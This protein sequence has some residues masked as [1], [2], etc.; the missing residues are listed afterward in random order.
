MKERYKEI[1][2]NLNDLKDI[3]KILSG[4][5]GNASMDLEQLIARVESFAEEQAL[6]P[7][8][9]EVGMAALEN[10]KEFIK[11]KLGIVYKPT[12]IDWSTTSGQFPGAKLVR[13]DIL[14]RKIKCLVP[15][16]RI[17]DTL[18]EEKLVNWISIT[19][20]GRYAYYVVYLP[21][22]KEAVKAKEDAC[23]S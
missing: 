3:L 19:T 5:I 15:Y 20:K 7:G 4:D 17:I 16:R 11:Q 13:V 22:C 2:K 14:Y 6:A 9:E 12:W 8:K 1:L 18:A 23:I 21:L 10:S